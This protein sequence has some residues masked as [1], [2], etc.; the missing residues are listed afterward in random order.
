MSQTPPT[1]PP[2]PPPTPPADAQTAL[3]E[4]LAAIPE[5]ER[6]ATATIVLP[7][8][9]KGALDFAGLGP[10]GFG[11][12]RA[13]D[14]PDGHVSAITGLPGTLR[15]L[16]I[17]ANDLTESP[18]PLPP[19]LEKLYVG[20]SGIY[21]IDL[22]PCPLLRELRISRKVG[23]M[24]APVE[25]SHLPADLER[26]EVA[27]RP[28]AYVYARPGAHRRRVDA[29]AAAPGG[30]TVE[31][32][33]VE[34]FKL[35]TGYE[36]RNAEDRRKL[37][38]TAPASLGE[39]MPNCINCRQRGGTVFRKA[40]GEYTASCG[41]AAA[42]CALNIRIIAGAFRDREDAV[43]ALAADAEELKTSIIRQRMDTVFKY[44]SEEQSAVQFEKV[45][46]EYV[47][48]SA[49]LVR[50]REA[51]PG[52]PAATAQFA[53]SDNAVHDHIAQVKALMAEYRETGRHE[54]LKEA[55]RIHVEALVPAVRAR[56]DIQWFASYMGAPE[57]SHEDP[58]KRPAEALVRVAVS[59]EARTY[60]VGAAP[61]V[62][63]W[64][65]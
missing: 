40:R 12:V 29:S 45:F 3:V 42:P 32:A 4:T 7:D 6:A 55:A 11:A 51:R 37:F 63:A 28:Y 5:A 41:N 43:R 21:V 59:P 61:T 52:D 49:A 39:W 18:A 30:R 57:V 25:I 53:E 22:A 47:A 54:V 16:R 23:A 44:A 46:A 36:T 64:V 56:S 65:M 15:E 38:K 17:G 58:A 27:G 62:A 19:M 2:P 10:S 24:A 31:S 26:A 33:L 35:K 34:Y 50:A 48:A 9:I 20:D 14:I 60:N 1:P 13:I 8:N